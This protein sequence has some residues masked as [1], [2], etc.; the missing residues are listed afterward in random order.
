MIFISIHQFDI[1]STSMFEFFYGENPHDSLWND[2]FE[3]N[4]ISKP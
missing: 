2:F 1:K 4:K 3:T